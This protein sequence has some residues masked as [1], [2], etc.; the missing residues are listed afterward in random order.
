VS[1]CGNA[2][3]F[4]ERAFA[5]VDWIFHC[6]LLKLVQSGLTEVDIAHVG[7]AN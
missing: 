5:D 6:I 7:Q 1:N 3:E 4:L 2:I